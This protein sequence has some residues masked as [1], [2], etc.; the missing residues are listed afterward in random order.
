VSRGVVEPLIAATDEGCVL[1][2]ASMLKSVGPCVL[3]AG[4]FVEQAATL[5]DLDDCD[6]VRAL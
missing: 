2:L 4:P 3:L 5:E 1:Q 6:R